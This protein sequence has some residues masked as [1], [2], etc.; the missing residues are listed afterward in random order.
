MKM[1]NKI[2][3]SKW[4]KIII[5][6]LLGIF[7]GKYFFY[8]DAKVNETQT[9]VKDKIWTCSMHPQIRNKNFGKCPICGMDLIVLDD[10]DQGDK[11]GISLT[12]NN[13][14]NSNIIV[15]KIKKY[16]YVDKKITLYGKINLD[17]TKL[18]SQRFHFSGRIERL[19]VN[20]IGQKIKKGQ[21]I[22]TIYSPELVVNQEEL[23][24]ALKNENYELVSII[25]KRLKLKKITDEQINEIKNNKKIKYYFD[26]E[27]EVTGV[28]TKKIINMG[29]H[30]NKFDTFFYLADLSNLWGVFEAYEEDLTWIKLGDKVRIN[31]MNASFD[32]I[33]AKVSF[34]DPFID[35]KRRIAF[36]R[37]NINNKK[38]I[39]K[40]QMIISG[41]FKIRKK[42]SK[43]V[44]P[45]TAVMWTGKRSIVYVRTKTQNGKNYFESKNIYLGS[46]LAD[47][48]IVEKGLKEGEYVV[49]NG[50]FTIDAAS[51][52]QDKNS[53]MNNKDGYVDPFENIPDGFKNDLALLY[54][55]Y[56]YLKDL[57]IKADDDKSINEYLNKIFK[58]VNS[59]ETQDLDEEQEIVWGDKLKE[60]N[61]NMKDEPFDIKQ[62]RD[63]FANISNVFIFIFKKFGI[64]QK[65]YI[66]KC[67]MRENLHWM[68]KDT[69]LSNPYYGS[70]ML[71][72]GF[73]IGE[74]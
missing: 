70:D 7:I 14:A 49:V 68:D 25:E 3:F 10:T 60:I 74:I 59:I 71:R 24:E 42:I 48:Y 34:I 35:P 65:A 29:D 58:R 22:A 23:L 56:L 64:N 1:K 13:I 46:Y 19:F 18:M 47:R 45:K 72:C 30:F 17:Q 12:D 16:N 38:N 36:V 39:Y 67:P 69:V 52:L 15:S 40:P 73:L 37:V 9:E 62:A 2:N 8:S 4:L 66:Y 53:M 5:T 61:Q 44:I 27:S 41:A 28:V 43:I 63:V 55:D 20:F 6:L 51:Q 33:E 26:I 50:A 31:F 32:N 21:K 54:K 57:L 11:D